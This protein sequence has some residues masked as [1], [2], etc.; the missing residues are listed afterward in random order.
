MHGSKQL[1]N[2]QEKA[3]NYKACHKAL[4]NQLNVME[5]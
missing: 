1:R 3:L 4:R 2:V 5:I